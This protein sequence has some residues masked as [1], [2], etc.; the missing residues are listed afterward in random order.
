V[1]VKTVDMHLTSSYRKLGIHQRVEPAA[2]LAEH[3][4]AATSR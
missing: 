2:A 1:T 3:D 4:C